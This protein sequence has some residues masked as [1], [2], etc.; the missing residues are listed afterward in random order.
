VA[1]L[2]LA[3]VAGTGETGESHHVGDTADDACIWIHPTDPSL[4]LLIGDDKDGG[5]MV[6]GL[7]GIELQY[8][9]GTRF[10][11]VDIRYNFPLAGTYSNGTAHAT[12]ALV[13]VGDEGGKQLDFFKVNPSTR[14][15]EPAGS[16][17][18]SGG[19]TPYG[20]C[21]YVSPVT[22]KYY[23]FVNDQ[24]GVTQQ[25]ELADGGNGAVRGTM[26]RQFDV[27]TQTEGCVADDVLG[28]FYIGEEDVGL[29]RYG[30]EPGAG[31]TRVQVDRTGSG[32]N[33]TA[34]VEGMSIYYAGSG[35]GYLVVSS[36]GNSMFNVYDRT[37]ANAYLGSFDVG[38]TGT[39]D[40]V[41][42]T[43]GLDVTNFPLGSGFP[44][45]MLIVHD[46]SNSG[47]T[48]SNYKLVR[49]DPVAAAMGLTVNTAWD[50]RLVGNTAVSDTIPPATIQDL[51]GTR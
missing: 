2:V 34:D 5:L 42:G 6:Y 31:S 33:L 48:A 23:Y 45:G 12:V 7:D 46:T 21:M 29:W 47:G 16:V 19:L 8:V 27:G 22:G 24:G 39:I 50:P 13:G 17:T 40:N 51:E 35:A 1:A 9:E 38:S 36:Q 15:L 4:S 30:A 44:Q 49:W 18:T 26:V 25:Y 43:D 11:N 37:G 20:S 41:T 32:G 10:N 28:I 14:R 3:L